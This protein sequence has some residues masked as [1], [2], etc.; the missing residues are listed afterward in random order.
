MVK[1]VGIGANVF[2]T[3]YNI[4]TYPTEDTKMR[5][6]ACKTAGGGPVATGLVAAQKLG[7]DTAY[8]GVLSDDNG[9]RFLK[10]DFEKYGVKTDLIEVKSGYRS[11]ASVLW[12]C[13]DTASRTCVFDKGD[14]PPLVLTDEQKQGVRDAEILM[15]DGNEM[16]AAVD[17]AAIARDSGTKVL[18][19]C[20]GL[21]EGVERLLALTD[22]MIPS[23]EFALGHT[24]CATAAE[25]AKKLFDLYSPEIVVITQ[26]KRGG[27]IYDGEKVTEY[28]I[29]PADVVDSNGSGD[30]FH[31]AFA[32]A[33]VKGFDYL[34]CCHFSSAVSALKC[35]GIGARESVPDFETVKNYLKENGYE[36]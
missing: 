14:L 25:A 2:D 15:V 10:A 5:A 17:A 22:I 13:A 1:I 20:G 32:A 23:E 30:V 24:G 4:P 31:G 6:T 9:G 27:I 11:F 8:I 7:E 3:L 19:D 33:L 18:Y 21:Y 36:L 34:K 29:Y 12:L 28:P 26:G 35:T 16:D